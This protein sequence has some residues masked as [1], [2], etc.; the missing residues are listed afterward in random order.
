VVEGGGDLGLVDWVVVRGVFS[1]EWVLK[2]RAV[3]PEARPR[4]MAAMG[5]E[6]R[7]GVMGWREDMGFG[8]GWKGFGFGGICLAFKSPKVRIQ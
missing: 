2:L 1:G 5:R 6:E 4:R 7:M 8:M 3:K